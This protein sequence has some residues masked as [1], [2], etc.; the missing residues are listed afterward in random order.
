VTI[1]PIEDDD[2]EIT[3]FVGFQQPLSHLTETEDDG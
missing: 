3:R 2:G 1:S